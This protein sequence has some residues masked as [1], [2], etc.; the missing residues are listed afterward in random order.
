MDSS[1]NHTIRTPAQRL[2]G[3]PPAVILLAIHAALAIDTARK[4]SATFDEMVRLTSGY[5]YWV[6]GDYRLDPVEPP[7]SKMWAALPLLSGRYRFPH[8]DQP[9]WWISDAESIGRQFFFGLE[10]DVATLLFHG[11]LMT[12]T[13]SVALGVVVYLWSRRLFGHKGA[14]LSLVLY[15]F[16]S[17]MLGHA[18]LVT[19]ELSACLFFVAALACLWWVL[20]RV[21]VVSV[22]AGGLSL[23]AL[24]LSKMSSP[25]IVPVGILML[26]ARLLSGRAVE[27]RLFRSFTVTGRAARAGVW[28]GVMAIQAALTVTGIWAVHR[29]RFEAMTHAVPGRDRH[30]VP[31]P[32]PPGMTSW[33]YVLRD[34]G[35][36]G[37]MA[38]FCRDRHLLP[39]AYLY[40]VALQAKVIGA[41]YG[42]LNGQ[43]RTTG[44]W[45]FF[46]Y[47]F[48]VKTSPAVFMILAL[49]AY[50]G[51]Q[52]QHAEADSPDTVRF[53][54]R[55]GILGI[56]GFLIVYWVAALHTSINI[57]HRHIL[58]IYPLLYILA[59]AAV[60]G[61]K[62]RGPLVRGLTLGSAGLFAL[63][64]FWTH[65]KHLA[66]FNLLIGGPANAYRHL[67]DSSLDWGQDLPGLNAWLGRNATIDRNGVRPRTYLSYFGTDNPERFG[68]D[69][70]MLPSHMEWRRPQLEPLTEGLYCISATMLQVMYLMPTNRWT[71]TFEAAYQILKPQY[72][73][74]TQPAQ[75]TDPESAQFRLLRFARLCAALRQRTP[76][77][78]V[79]YTILVY[80]LTD[81][82]LHQILDGPP[83]E[84]C[85]D[86]PQDGG[87]E[88]IAW[89]RRLA[90]MYAR[91]G[92]T[93]QA[94]GQ[95]RRALEFYPKDAEAAAELGQIL[96]SSG[97]YASADDVLRRAIA[98]NSN[99]IVLLNDLAWLRATC[100]HD[101][102]R[103][104]PQA[105]ELSERAC[106]IAGQ[107]RWELLDTL[108]AAFAECGRFAEALL[109]A[110]R[111]AD[112]AGQ[113]GLY[114]AA[115]KVAGRASLYENNKPYRQA[116]QD[117]IG[118]R[119]V[120][121]P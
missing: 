117:G 38:A 41:G 73:S 61:L 108:A 20:Q 42:F 4:T 46:P 64:S 11:R 118:N 37:R 8:L 62:E 82:E 30:M 84:R 59:G 16:C 81:Q 21:T 50:A 74:T 121:A 69:A 22:L 51:R 101:T 55:L 75:M 99:D 17:N 63:T 48:A 39:E 36:A 54:V 29:F 15:A 106:R 103:N 7:L 44:W 14:L 25:L 52:K 13:M 68:I 77:D 9:A 80:R 10:N 90:R 98:Q 60:W 26:I 105:V 107:D 33:D 86:R 104:G 116:S 95:Y 93:N 109:Y 88:H 112:M 76:D 94:A 83:M 12:V 27:V 70:V 85:A 120:P 28:V 18:P 35:V 40:G 110:R 66:Y 67:V 3:W 6:T 47:A 115:E 23:A 19:T 53:G 65:P 2:W 32:L 72:E 87:L 34:C 102:I 100:P 56:G 45:Y 97:D 58:P 111:A 49:A 92:L 79:N 31:G 113:A 114:E 78:Q 43:R 96:S 57:G 5:A 24:F 89:F 71:E 119:P 91:R 1:G